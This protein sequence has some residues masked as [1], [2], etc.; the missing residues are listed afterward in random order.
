MSAFTDLD[1]L[2][3]YEKD[4]STAATGYMALATRAADSDLRVRFLQLATEAGKVHEKV[5]TMIERAGGIA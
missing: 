3:D 1:M 5:S 2:Y 4:I